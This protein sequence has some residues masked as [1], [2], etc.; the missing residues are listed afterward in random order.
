M[1]FWDTSALLSI[2]LPQDG[3]EEVSTLLASGGLAVWWGTQIEAFS[4]ISRLGRTRELEEGAAKGASHG[5]ALLIA[6]AYQVEPSESI[7]SSACRIVQVYPLTAADALQLA[8]ALV[9]TDHNPSGVGFVCLDGRLCEAARK[10][11]F[12]V[13]P[14]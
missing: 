5:I 9:W 13:L 10:E 1:R 7:R 4:A 8:A 6:S 11:G 3:S 14:R 2:V 12:D